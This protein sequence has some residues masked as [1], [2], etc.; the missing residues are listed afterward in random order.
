[1]EKVSMVEQLHPSLI[2]QF[3][4]QCL[5]CI[6]VKHATTGLQSSRDA[7]SEVSHTQLSGSLMDEAGFG[8]QENDTCLTDQV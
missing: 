8:S 5:G 6:G 4:M 2:F 1:M 7:F 3:A